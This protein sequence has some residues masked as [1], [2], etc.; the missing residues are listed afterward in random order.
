MGRLIRALT[1]N[2]AWTDP[3]SPDRRLR[4]REYP[5]PFTAVWDAVL[6]TARSRPRWSVIQADARRGEIE[7]EARTGVWRFV[8]DVLIRISLDELGLTR[9]DM[10][11]QSRV[12]RADLGVNARRIARFLHALDRRLVPGGNGE[13]S[14]K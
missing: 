10:T 9:V 8:D 6:E 7:V 1:R 12:G 3:E 13:K 5:V 11:S 14:R 2:R 4:G